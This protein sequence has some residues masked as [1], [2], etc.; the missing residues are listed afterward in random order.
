MV[1]IDQMSGVKGDEPLSTLAKTRNIGGKTYFGRH[2]CLSSGEMDGMGG[3]G[4]EGRRT[5]MVG[6]RVVPAYEHGQE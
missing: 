4:G 2:V 3:G 6:D 1:C 5:V